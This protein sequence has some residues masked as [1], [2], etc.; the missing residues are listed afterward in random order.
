[1][2]AHLLFLSVVT[3]AALTSGACSV[4]ERNY[5]TPGSG[6]GA[7]ASSSSSTGGDGGAGGAQ[8]GIKEACAAYAAALC[9]RNTECVPF[10]R[11]L[12]YGDES[13]CAA[14]FEIYCSAIV[15]APGTSWTPEGF[16]SCASALNTASCGDFVKGILRGS[17]PECRPAPGALPDGAPCID[18]GQCSGGYCNNDEPD[19]CGVCTTHAGEG[20]ACN[21]HLDCK[22]GLACDLSIS[23]CV[24]AGSEGASCAVGQTLCEFPLVCHNSKCGAGAAA[25]EMCDPMFSACP[26]PKG[27]FCDAQTASCKP[28]VLVKEGADCGYIN[29]E[30]HQC[31]AS[32]RCDLGMPIPKCVAP[33]PDGAPCN[34]QGVPGCMPPA[35][36]FN[37][38]CTLPAPDACGP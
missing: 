9:A 22:L 20:E 30:S 2:R 8:V 4:E 7:G 32:G 37:G 15:N 29:G 16:L 14:R 35:I 3:A 25:G 31:M 17:I 34:P 23:K 21:A 18:S 28:F 10:F 1:M 38:S 5:G 27:L 36:C 12:A 33:A 11:E 19:Q 13:V 6:G 24:V 26:F